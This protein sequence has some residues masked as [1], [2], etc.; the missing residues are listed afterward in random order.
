VS[1]L[2][3][4]PTIETLRDDRRAL[5]EDLARLR[6]RLRL[7]LVLEVVVEAAVAASAIGAVLVQLDWQLRLGLGVR[8][9]LLALSLSALVYFVA[10]RV[11]RRWRSSRLD[12][13]GLA[14]TLDH[15]R[16]GLGQQV[17]D[18][19]QLPDLVDE[20][21]SAVSPAMV[22]LAVHQAR[23]A[24]ARS[25]WRSL[26]N[27]RRTILHTG[28]LALAA[29]APIGFAAVAPD[30]ARLSF[31][32][33]LLGSS[34]RWPQRTYLSVMGLNDR[35]RLIAARDER[36]P[37]EVRSD[38][39][40]IEPRGDRWSVGG[41][42]EPLLLRR[43]PGRP[44]RPGGIEIRER[45]AIGPTRSGTMVESD[46]SGFRYELPSSSTSSTFELT[47]GDDWLGPITVDRVDRPTLSATRLRVKEPGASVAG[48]RE[49]DDVGRGLLFLPDSEVEMTLVGNEALS[50]AQMK[51]YP[52]AVPEL[53]RLD[54]RSFV[55]SWTL[56]EAVTLEIVVVSAD[57]GLNS[58]TS[59]LSI[60]ILRDREPRVTLRASGVSA[61]VTPVATIPLTLAAT[62]DFGLSALRIQSDRSVLVDEAGKRDE[63]IEHATI[64]LPFE[65][66][67]A[68]PTLDHQVRH[69]LS[70]QSD[71]PKPG[72]TLRFTGEAD[73]H[74]ARGT[75][76]GRSSV[77]IF[78]VVSPDEL[79]YEILIRQR[80]ERTKF[81]SVLEA[82][83]KNEPTLE[84]AAT[85]EEIIRVMR[86]EQTGAR[87]LEQITGRVADTLQE[88]KLNQIGS[89]KSHRLLQEGVVDPLRE[90]TTGPM[91]QLRGM[92]QTLAAEAG[93]PGP[94]KDAARRLHAEVVTKMKIILEQMSQWESFVDVVNQVAEVIKMERKVLQET[95]KARDTRTQEVFDDK[96]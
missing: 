41:R 85:A 69:D 54:D 87:Q 49:I 79:F 17:A 47:G 24:L 70:L 51:M 21:R 86:T 5:R 2:D 60:G 35:G 73:D 62:D 72:A 6:R 57:S 27:R 75:Q 28:A 80:A 45:A 96:P 52:G 58:K 48:F 63:K 65:S 33:W 36:V 38:L 1:I 68:R 77:L 39:P 82:T 88:M 90:L 55:A 84:K 19:L 11:V 29:A 32:R 91:A 20:P 74:C 10:N 42:G 94:R 9:A 95:E 13:L 4:L 18:V 66:D 89:P 76:T 43:K 46:P 34:E 7:E 61:H 31:A 26:W 22:R 81:L 16:P 53:K 12:E 37:I 3:D 93:T 78:Q 30:A 44:E 50:K 8:V 23:E 67:P 64:K 40:L 92:L 25:D 83:E 15:F 14:V 56:T 59:F 71:P